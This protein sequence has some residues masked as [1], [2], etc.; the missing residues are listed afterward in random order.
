MLL[1]KERCPENFCKSHPHV[2]PPPDAPEQKTVT[3]TSENVPHLYQMHML[4]QCTGAEDSNPNIIKWTL[5]LSDA[6][7]WPVAKRASSCARQMLYDL[8]QKSS[9]RKSHINPPPDAPEQ[10]TLSLTPASENVHY[11]Y[12]MH[13]LGQTRKGHLIVQGNLH[14][15]PMHG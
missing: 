15:N 10:K 6:H 12:Q 5:S 7:A 11:L 4:G 13:M 8:L 2:N 1:F 9:T 3:P 14:R